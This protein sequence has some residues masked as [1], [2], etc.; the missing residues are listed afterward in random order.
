MIINL[1]RL[2]TGVNLSRLWT[3]VNL[4]RL[5]TGV[6]GKTIAANPRMSIFEKCLKSCFDRPER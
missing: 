5:W 1:S 4:S 3:G 2:W 6:Y